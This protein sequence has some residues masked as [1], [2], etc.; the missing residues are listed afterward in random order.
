MDG[1]AAVEAKSGDLGLCGGDCDGWD[2]GDA[3]VAVDDGDDDKGASELL[4][5]RCA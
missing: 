2:D 4:S 3:V 1:D 5:N